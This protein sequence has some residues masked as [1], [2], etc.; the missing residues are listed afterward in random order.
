MSFSIHINHE[1]QLLYVEGQGMITAEDIDQYY[2]DLKEKLGAEYCDKALVNLAEMGVSLKAAPIKRIRSLGL[3]FK[4][5][6]VL[7]EGAKMAIVVRSNLAFGFV[8]LFMASRG[9]R[10]IIRPFKSMQQAMSWLSIIEQ[11]VQQAKL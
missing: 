8:R 6:P 7:P 3:L 4:H 10:V 2:P 1:K 5:A 11:D 9:E